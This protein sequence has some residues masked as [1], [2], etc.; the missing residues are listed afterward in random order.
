MHSV[1]LLCGTTRR[2]AASRGST[3]LASASSS[4]STSTARVS[5]HRVHKASGM[6]ARTRR[7]N[8]CLHHACYVPAARLPEKTGGSMFASAEDLKAATTSD[9]GKTITLPG[10][11]Q[12]NGLFSGVLYVRN[13]YEDMWASVLGRC[14]ATEECNAAVVLGLPG[15][16]SCRPRHGVTAAPRPLP[17][18]CGLLVHRRHRLRTCAASCTQHDPLA[19]AVCGRVARA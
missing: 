7:M 13:F 12:W 3:A 14:I 15:G 19:C 11:A 16:E 17:V 18:R 10:D 8:L 6:S 5:S 2:S 9:D 4:S 1:Q